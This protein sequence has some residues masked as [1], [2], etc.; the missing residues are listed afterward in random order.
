MAP[1]ATTPGSFH[2]CTGT[3]ISRRVVLTAERCMTSP[4]VDPS[5]AKW[6]VVI[7]EKV[8]SA[9][10]SAAC[11][12]AWAPGPGAEIVVPTAYEHA[13]H[14]GNLDPGVAALILPPPSTL[15]SR[16]S[17]LPLASDADR[18]FREIGSNATFY[19]WGRTNPDDPGSDASAPC[20]DARTLEH[21]N[22][23]VGGRVQWG[24]V[25]TSVQTAP[26]ARA[27]TACFGDSGGPLIGNGVV[28]GMTQDL[29]TAHPRSCAS[30]APMFV[31]TWE[32]VVPD[33]LSRTIGANPTRVPSPL[34]AGKTM[35]AGD[36]LGSP[37][38]LFHLTMQADGGLSVFRSRDNRRGWGSHTSGH[39]GASVTV[40]P[41][42]NVVVSQ[43]QQGHV[44]ALCSTHTSGH[45]GAILRMQDNGNVVVSGPDHT[46]LW[47]SGKQ[48]C[49]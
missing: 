6:R 37:R 17:P 24:D 28:V 39:P 46:S 1:D 4:S 40:Q 14:V 11:P 8:T 3:L 2:T 38:G 10:R 7:G 32:G 45:P 29:V 12:A 23:V 34:P 31:L 27:P 19:G 20:S 16:P 43:R 15:S 13:R 35:F 18:A 41:D 48:R 42:G 9:V 21:G 30:N 47:D 44:V 22:M 33:F 36:D 26:P 5:L 49:S 25:F